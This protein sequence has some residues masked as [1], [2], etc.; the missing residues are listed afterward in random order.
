MLLRVLTLF[1]IG[2]SA[3]TVWAAEPKIEITSATYG[4]LPGGP[5]TDVK[6]LIA[7]RSRRAKFALKS[8][9]TCSRPGPT[10]RQEAESRLQGRWYRALR[11]AARRG[12]APDSGTGPERRSSDPESRIRGIWTRDR[13]RCHRRRE[14]PAQ[15]R[16]GGSRSQ[17]RRVRRPASG[18]FKQL[19]VV[20][21]IG[22]VEL[23]KRTYEG[24]R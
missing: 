6:D 19:R 8:R 7:R 10:A 5:S 18:I 4:V 14:V 16:S 2:L 3:Q 11:H 22:D 17:Q 13:L 21:K 9:T 24:V 23:V 1:V 12:P 15:G 20:Y